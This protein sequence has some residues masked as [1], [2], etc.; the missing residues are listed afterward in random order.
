M[1]APDR[2]DPFALHPVAPGRWRAQVP[3]DQAQGRAAFGGLLAGMGGRAVEALVGADRPLRGVV[4]D[5]VAPVVPG[6]VELAATVLREG[7]ALTQVEVRVLQAGAPAVVALYAA[8][9]VRPTRLAVAGPPEP[10]APAGDPVVLPYLEGITPAFTRHYEFAWL[11][12]GFPFSGAAAPG[13][14]GRIRPRD[15]RPVDAAGVLALLDAWPCPVLPLADR[16]VPASTVTWMANLVRPVPAAPPGAWWR[17]E[18]EAVASD[19]GYVDVDARL[20]AP[21]GGLVATSRQ[22]VV[23]FSG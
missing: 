22:L 23:E 7:R 14:G 15:G 17:F 11:R 21:D 12:G 10:P 4:V 13:L 8:G 6:E 16:V 19:E 2:P 5:F 1:P 9:A 20:W 3:P 18:S